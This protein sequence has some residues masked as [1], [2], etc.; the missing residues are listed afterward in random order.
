ML[1]DFRLRVFVT[2]AECG[3]FTAA[4]LKLNITQ[5]AVSRHIAELERVLGV[6]LLERN[7]NAVTL[8]EAG[9]RFLGYARQILHWYH[10]AQRAFHPDPLL[11]FEAPV[12]PVRLPLENGAEALVWTSAGDIHIELPAPK[13]D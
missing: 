8:T 12:E 10:V 3:S 6:R 1:E 11:P 2:V 4:A 13:E 5:P 9:T 7:R